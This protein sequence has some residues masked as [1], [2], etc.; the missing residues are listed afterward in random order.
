MSSLP[1]KPRA[2]AEHR[3][4]EAAWVVLREL[5]KQRGDSLAGENSSRNE[6][7]TFTIELS[8]E[9]EARL[10]PVMLPGETLE[11]FILRCQRRI[12]N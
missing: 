4:S 2:V 7:G 6:D 5:T 8:D 9:F 12:N 11:E 10:F 1:R 3:V